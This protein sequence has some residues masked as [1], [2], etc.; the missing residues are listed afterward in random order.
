MQLLCSCYEVIQE[1]VGKLWICHP[2]PAARQR[3]KSRCCCPLSRDASPFHICHLPAVMGLRRN[4]ARVVYGVPDPL[5]RRR[6]SKSV[7]ARRQ[8]TLP[9]A[10]N[11][12][13][14]RRG[15]GLAGHVLPR[16]AAGGTANGGT[17]HAPRGR[18][19]APAF[20]V[21]RPAL[22]RG[23]GD[24]DGRGR[25]RLRPAAAAGAAA[26]LPSWRVHGGVRGR[27]PLQVA[28]P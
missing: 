21:P 28:L 5:R 27:R 22:L 26:V 15:A 13:Q 6:L 7:T 1:H 14:P 8:R 11:R 17:A 23:A 18:S 25:S 19:F 24:D 16:R 2:Q 12:Q 10:P 3:R 4:A 20:A 9:Y